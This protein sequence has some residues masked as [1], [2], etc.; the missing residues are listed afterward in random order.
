[1]TLKLPAH[2]SQNS[3][4]VRGESGFFEHID[5][6]KQSDDKNPTTSQTTDLKLQPESEAEPN[7]VI[8]YICEGPS[9]SC[10][11]FFSFF[12]FYE[13]NLINFVEM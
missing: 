6:P 9:K 8:K 10:R 11:N 7:L 4:A 13:K 1:M 3:P 2:K 12:F 5:I